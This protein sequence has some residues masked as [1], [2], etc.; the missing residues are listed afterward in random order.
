MKKRALSLAV[1]MCSV[2]AFMPMTLLAA[3][4]YTEKRAEVVSSNYTRYTVDVSVP[5]NGEI[6]VNSKRITD[7]SLLKITV[8]PDFGY[9]LD[10]ITA[11]TKGGTILTVERQKDG[12]YGVLMPK[13]DVS[14]SATFA[15]K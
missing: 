13:E 9:K 7:G 5:N 15:V 10:T 1:V 12:T 8:T 2:S 4:N 3:E 14:V 6:K 11:T